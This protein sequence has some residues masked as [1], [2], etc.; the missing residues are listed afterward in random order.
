VEAH[1]PPAVSG[2][3]QVRREAEEEDG[4]DLMAGSLG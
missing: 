3:G 1:F 2:P 4:V